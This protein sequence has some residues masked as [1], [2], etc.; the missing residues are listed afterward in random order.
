MEYVFY[1][2]AAVCVAAVLFKVVELFSDAIG[3]GSGKDADLNA[4]EAMLKVK[5]K[6]IQF[7]KER[8]DRYSRHEELTREGFDRIETRIQ[9]LLNSAA[10]DVAKIQYETYK[11]A[12]ADL[13]PNQPQRD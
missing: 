5:E 2:V 11:K 4:A 13:K 8:G 1:S 6:E 12:V 10:P 7:W 3:A 9:A